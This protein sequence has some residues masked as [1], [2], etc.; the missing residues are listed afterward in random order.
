MDRCFEGRP[1][2]DTQGRQL[3]KPEAEFTLAREIEAR[4]GPLHLLPGLQDTQARFGYSDRNLGIAAPDPFQDPKASPPIAPMPQGPPKKRPPHAPENIRGHPYFVEL[5]GEF[6]PKQLGVIEIGERKDSLWLLPKRDLTLEVKVPKGT[7]PRVDPAFVRH[8]YQDQAAGFFQPLLQPA[9]TEFCLLW[10]DGGEEGVFGS[11]G[12]FP[13]DSEFPA[14][15]FVREGGGHNDQGGGQNRLQL[16]LKTW[17]SPLGEEAEGGVAGFEAADAAV[18]DAVTA[19]GETEGG[20][21]KIAAIVEDADFHWLGEE[22]EVYSKGP[23]RISGKVFWQQGAE[24][25]T[26]SS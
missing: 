18:V 11:Y 17:V 1:A 26:I 3:V 23:I 12:S 8:I 7:E 16:C 25:A 20:A 22:S 19:E 24:E 10:I 2:G 14:P 13:L 6:R 15:G 21:A 5:A 9:V 4:L